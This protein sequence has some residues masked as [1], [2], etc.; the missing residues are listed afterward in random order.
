MKKIKLKEVIDVKRGMSLAGKHYSYEGSIVRLTLGNF[1]YPQNGF[2]LNTSKDDIYFNGPYK[3]ECLLKKGDIITPLTEQVRGL[4]GSTATIP[5]DNK[6][7]QSGDIGLIIPNERI[8]DKRFAYYL[9]SSPIVKKQLDS[10]SQQT[11]IRHTSPDAI[12]ECFAYFPENIKLQQSIA[13]IFDLINNKIENNNKINHELES[14]AKTIYDYWF[15]QFNFPNEEGKP[16][17]SSGGEM[18]YNEKLKREIPVHWKVDEILNHVNWVSNSQPPKSQFCYK[19]KEG[20]V[21]FIQNR[22]YDSNKHITYIPDKKSLSKVNK[23]DIL[24]D[25]YG[26]AGK[27]RYGIEGVFNVALGKIEVATAN[28][29]EYIRSFLSSKNIY[30]YLHNSCMASTRASL[31]EENLKLLY[32]AIPTQNIL[33]KY[34]NIIHTYREIILNLKEENQELASLSDFLLPLLM[35]GQVTIKEAE[36]INKTVSQVKTF[37][38][39]NYDERFEL[40]LQN[41]GVAARGNIDRQTLREIFD[42]MDDDDK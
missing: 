39:P 37:V 17:K 40:W 12:K 41:Q 4:L 32:I 34:E 13:K 6:Y 29:L 26:V 16:Y 14:M 15:I 23:F 35:N 1:R 22:D 7:L 21:R 33:T 5:E 25:K 11:K 24:I 10:A 36:D 19:P 38:S 8:I 31:S 2:K 18:V 27:V 9:V 28:E 3:S 42:A 20:F 30:E